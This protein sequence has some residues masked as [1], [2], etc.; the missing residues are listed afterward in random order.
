M[1]IAIY[2]RNYSDDN[3]PFYNQIFNELVQKKHS[4]LIHKELW[5]VISGKFVLTSKTKVFENLSDIVDQTDFLFSI[6]GDGTL[7]NT[8]SIVRDSNIP[9]LGFNT[10]RL[11][12]I[13]SISKEEI[14]LAIEVLNAGNYTTEKRSVLSLETKDN[15]FNNENFALNEICIHKKES[16]SMISIHAFVNNLFLNTYWADGLIIATPTG[17]T[18]YSLSCGGPIVTPDSQNIIITPISTHNLTVR[19]II[20]PDSSHIRLHAEGREDSFLVSIDS[21]S[22]SINSSLELKIAK[23]PFFINLIKLPHMNFFNT[24]REKLMWGLDKRN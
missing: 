5:D 18:A 14:S 22:T 9:V 8:I 11:G 19:P 24:I 23:A 7:L 20:I 12:F 4:I 16:S 3:F 21:R 2:G 17:S 15:L 13:S 6:G 1:R 10:G